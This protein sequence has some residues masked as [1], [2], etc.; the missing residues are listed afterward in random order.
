MSTKSRTNQFHGVVWEFNRLSAYTSNTVLNAQQGLPKGT[1]TRNQ[2]GFAVG[3]PIKKDKLFF[4]GSTEW[5]R[6]SSTAV[7][8]A[9]VPTPQFLALSAANTQKFFADYSGGKNFNFTKTY[10]AGHLGIAGVP[11]TT[12]AFG[13]VAYTAPVNTGGSVP[14]NTYNIVGRFDY[15]LSDRTQVFFRYANYNEADQIGSAFASPYN[16]YNVGNAAFSTAYLLS[17][18]HVF[19]PYLSETTKLSFSRF[20][21]PLTYNTSLQNTP[22]LI[23]STNAQLPGT[24]TF[25]QL[26]GFYD[27]NPANGGL[28]FGGPQN[29]IQV[30]QDLNLQKGRHS[31]QYG[32]QIMYIQAINDHGAHAP[33]SAYLGTH[34]TN[35][36][37]ELVR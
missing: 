14:Q 6:V 28:P 12:P 30:N 16:Q 4:F 29:T 21:A 33:A 35:G 11:A 20:N 31:M 3:G 10:T 18:N 24:S 34:R 19:N 37:N 7:S 5:T 32:A 26:P 25:I 23:V 1:Y 22:T 13:T 36:L 17:A 2:F 15:N 8:I 9:A 27:F